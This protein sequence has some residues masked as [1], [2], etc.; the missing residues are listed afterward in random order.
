[1]EFE[2]AA[3]LDMNIVLNL[4]DAV[5]ICF[6]H[7]VLVVVVVVV[8]V[9]APSTV[10]VEELDH[11]QFECKH[12]E[13]LKR[14]VVDLGDLAAVALLEVHRV[15]LESL[16]E[17]LCLF[18]RIHAGALEIELKNGT[19]LLGVSVLGHIQLGVDSND[20]LGFGF[21]G[22]VL[23]AGSHKPTH[24]HLCGLLELVVIR[25]SVLVRQDW[26]TLTLARARPPDWILRATI[27]D[28]LAHAQGSLLI[29]HFAELV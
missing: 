13:S 18:T 3:V 22:M 2:V 4:G 7:S 17:G 21:V 14:R 16:S 5:G 25:T 9:F 11:L 23:E 26:Q 8:N 1:M 24:H 15:L 6:L 27:A 28:A 29:V 10:K 20:R 12:L 19:A